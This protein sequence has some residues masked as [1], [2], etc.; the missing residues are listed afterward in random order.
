M[1]IPEPLVPADIARMALFLIE[2][3][4]HIRIPRL[5]ILPKGHEI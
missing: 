4:P 5:M 2:Q 1:G 3:P